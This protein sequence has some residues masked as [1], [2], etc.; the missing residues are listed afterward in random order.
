MAPNSF[1]PC[2]LRVTGSNR[3]PGFS[4]R[5]LRSAIEA[6]AVVASSS[7]PLSSIS[8]LSRT[9]YE[10]FLSFR[11]P[12]T[13]QGFADYLFRDLIHA[14]IMVFKDDE[15]LDPG[16]NVPDALVQS[17]KQS[18]ISI[19]ILSQDYANS[20]SCLMELAQMVECQEAGTQMVVPIFYNVSPADLKYQ[21]NCVG[22]AFRKHEERGVDRMVIDNWKQALKKIADMEGYGALIDKVVTDILELL[23]KNDL[24]VKNGLVGMELHV[25]EVM[26]K[27]GVI[28]VNEQVIGVHDKDVRVLGIV[29]MPGIGKTTLA[30]VVYNKIHHLFQ[31]CSSLSNVRENGTSDNLIMGLQ[32]QLISHLRRK[33]YTNLRTLDQMTNFIKSAF[34]EMKVLILLDDVHHF[35]QIRHLVGD[36]NWF[37]PGSRILMTVGN[38]DV[39]DGYGDGVGDKYEVGQMRTDQAF[40]LFCMRA[41]SGYTCEEEDEYDRLARRIVET[42][43]GIPLAI[44]VTA[45]YLRSKRGNIEI[46]KAVLRRLTTRPA[47]EVHE[48]IKGNY[49]SLKG[50]TRKIF[51]DIACFFI[52]MDARIPSYMWDACDYYSPIGIELLRNMSFIKIGENNELW[53]HNELTKFGREIVRRENENEPR[54]RSRLW[55]HSDALSTLKGAQSTRKVEALG[56]IFDEGQSECFTREEFSHLQSLRFLRLD[57]ATVGG[58]SENVLPN[59]QWLGYIRHWLRLDRAT[60]RGSSQ[61]VLPNLRWLDWQGCSDISEL[62]IFCLEK[63]V[64]LDLSRSL[65]TGDPKV[66][67]QILKM[68]KELKVLNLSGCCNLNIFLR[69]PASVDLQSLDL[70]R[71]V[72]EHCSVLSQI[73]PFIG[74]LKNLVSLN[75]KFCKFISDLP[76]ELCHMID[77]EELLI[78]GTAIREID[79]KPASMKKLEI[80]SACQCE[81]LTLISDSIGHLESLVHLRLEGAAIEWLPDS[82]ESLKK[83]RSLLLGNCQNLLELPLSIG[84]LKSLEVMDLSSTRVVSLPTS[85]KH[86]K[87]LKVLKMEKTHLQEFP[88]EITDL[89]KLEEID[90]SECRTLKGLIY[91]DMR[92]L[93]SLKILR[94]SSTGISGLPLTL[95][96][97][98]D[99]RQLD[100]RGCDELRYLQEL[101]S[102]LSILRWG[103]KIMWTVPDLSFLRNL[104]ELYLGDNFSPTDPMQNSSPEPP[105]IGWLAR[106]ASL[107]I[108][109]LCHSKIT[110]LPEHFSKLKL[111]KLVLHHAC[112][113]DLGELPSS[114]S[115]LCL[116]SCMIQCSLFSMVTDLSE[117]KLK[118]CHLAETV[119]LKDLRRL[120]FLKISNCYVEK[121]DGLEKLPRFK[122]LTLFNSPSL[123]GLPDRTNCKFE[124]DVYNFPVEQ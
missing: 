106:L 123:I 5:P 89:E 100:L 55:N 31:C 3:R 28:Y 99:L 85:V 20:K 79:F 74:N 118:R 33:E 29:G 26:K 43:G 108:L 81:R 41:F 39:L 88:N 17:I 36:L 8:T 34:S 110:K 122:R 1:V 40:E 102:S 120:E 87:N 91:C 105:Q 121:L 66:W 21:L 84:N 51:L 58:I 86:L 67:E 114:L 111:R 52:G 32:K 65:V 104:K 93:S 103:S 83:L 6:E 113:Y 27:L 48:L 95:G 72:L 64:I 47:D 77:L 14:R 92:G 49:D 60:V 15:E 69:F 98:S 19:P 23:K 97:L 96:L 124:I 9:N 78:D 44:E 82:I 57:K 7:R 54:E 56:L 53:M 22:E 61:N 42:I 115:V 24:V 63:L 38:I 13:R 107:E 80:L 4:S 45:S 94:L 117:L 12:D 59:S 46:W 30:K 116:H 2:C 76:Q 10:V 16:E 18:K 90:L 50:D 119:N 62:L 11:G 109:K 70:Q 68:A 75:L 25:Q 73:G 101:P 71:L 37:G 112:L 35:D